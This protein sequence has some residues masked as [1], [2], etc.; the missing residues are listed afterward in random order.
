MKFDPGKPYEEFRVD[1]IPYRYKQD[2]KFFLANGQECNHRG[3]TKDKSALNYENGDTMK[4]RIVP[5]LIFPLS[6]I[7]KKRGKS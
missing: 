1:R 5:G 6:R 2:G 3:L 7:R 4:R